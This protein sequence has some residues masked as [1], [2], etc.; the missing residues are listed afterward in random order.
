MAVIKDKEL[1]IEDFRAQMDNLMQSWV[2]ESAEN[3]Q[4]RP[5]HTEMSAVSLGNRDG[6]PAKGEMEA[7]RA[8]VHEMDVPMVAPDSPQLLLKKCAMNKGKKTEGSYDIV[9]PKAQHQ[10]DAKDEDKKTGVHVTLGDA[11][12][13]N[14]GSMH[15]NTVNIKK[16][17]NEETSFEA[18]LDDS[19]KDTGKLPVRN[20][21][22]DNIVCAEMIDHHIMSSHRSMGAKEHLSKTRGDVHKSVEQS[23]GTALSQK[24][25]GAVSKT[26]QVDKTAHQLGN[27][28]P[29][30]ASNQQW[31]S[32]LQERKWRVG[33]TPNSGNY[34]QV[35][36]TSTFRSWGKHH[37]CFNC[38][39]RG[40]YARNCD[41]PSNSF[42]WRR[43][44][45]SSGWNRF[46][47]GRADLD[48]DWRAT[49]SFRS[50]LPKESSTTVRCNISEESSGTKSGPSLPTFNV[51]ISPIS[52][53]KSH[54][55]AGDNFW[56][57][58]NNFHILKPQPSVD[59]QMS[60]KGFAVANSQKFCLSYNRHN[61]KR[62]CWSCGV[63][64]HIAKHCDVSMRSVRNDSSHPG[65]YSRR[66]RSPGAP[67]P[68]FQPSAPVQT[69]PLFIPF[70]EEESIKL[71]PAVKFRP[72]LGR[73]LRLT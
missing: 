9:I 46:I 61:R 13:N 14:I 37:Q 30:V 32:R 5:V 58:S 3:I 25:D 43:R 62:Q 51:E 66:R 34:R 24:T 67:Q 31:F 33:S 68:W 19:P 12:P 54:C 45:P 55:D 10:I 23:S 57:Q 26:Q 18:E 35:S 69:G 47:T 4:I 71:P 20:T 41:Q 39:F 56:S 72:I 28:V 21:T 1:T 65:S 44:S 59:D 38:G 49:R 27:A 50:S 42:N 70:P 63:W 40:H 29:E 15:P 52:Q 48:Q 8:A 6:S 22:N 73:G 60:T 16:M 17:Q 2:K 64:G 36:S 53:D 11:N 7:L